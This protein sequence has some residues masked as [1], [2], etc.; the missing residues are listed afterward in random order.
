ERKGSDGLVEAGAATP[1]VPEGLSYWEFGT[2]QKPGTKA[3]NDYTARL[4]STTPAERANATFIFVTPRNWPGKTEWERRKNAAGDWKAVRALD[5]SNLEQW[6]EQSVPAQIWFAEKIALPVSGYET[7]D[8]CWQRWAAASEPQMTPEAFAPSIAAY[9]GKFEI[10]L[11]KPSERSFVVAADSTDEALAFLACLFETNGLRQSKDLAAVFTSAETLKTLVASSVPFV[12]IVYSQDGERE[13]AIAHRRL[14]CIVVRPRNA[15]D[16]EADMA[17]DMLGHE[18]FEKALSAMGIEDDRVERLARESGRSPTI[19]RRRLS[20]IDA[21][22]TPVWAGDAGTAKALIPM[23]LIGAWHAES[24]AD[25]E[26]AKYLADRPYEAIEDDIVRLRL[27]DDCPV[28][29]VGRYRGIASKIDALFA[30]ANIVMKPYLDRFF[31]AAEYVLSE[32][33]PALD[34]PEGDRWAAAVYGKKRDHS[35][36]LREGICETLVIL[37]IHGNKLFQGRLGINIESR[38]AV[39]IRQL[40]TPLTIDKLQSQDRDLPRYAEAAPDEFLK[41][42]EEDL[43]S[44]EPV[45]YGLLKPV[46]SGMFGAWPSRTGLL[47]ALECLAWKPQNLPRVAAVLAQLSR[48]KIDDNWSNKPESSLHV[49][50]RSWMPQTA[51]SV[52]QRMKT[53]ETLAKRFPDVGWRICVAQFKPGSRFG[54]S[55]YRPRWRSDASGA[56]QVVTRREVYDFTRKALDLAIAWPR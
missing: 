33:D 1:W 17:L 2:D 31:T 18:A 35:A 12:P 28:W 8:R 20:P 38:V 30:I 5:A 51:A 7:L 53:L 52:E 47:W 6:L 43:K 3:E 23:T 32:S 19:L 11:D 42:I 54:H 15:I 46:D 9:Q 13:L 37:S 4:G 49:I 22:K 27:F 40:L 34:L 16:T 50:F 55:S 39:L 24:E 29:S 21:I 45:V 36:A 44:P 48:P 41:L 26:I 25:R 14:H 10:W 56:G